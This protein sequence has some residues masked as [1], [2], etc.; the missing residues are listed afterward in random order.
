MRATLN[1]PS[2]DNPHSRPSLLDTVT[3]VS[4]RSRR[5]L[6]VV[7]ALTVMAA[8]VIAARWPVTTSVGVNYKVTVKRL[9]LFEKAIAFVDR[10]LEMRRLTREIAETGGAP[11]QRLLRMYEWVT[12]NIHPVPPG[13]PVVDD[14]VFDIF[15]R[16][17]GAND[18]RAEALAAL[19]SYDGMPATTIALGKNPKR[20]LVQ[21]TV[22]RI[23]DRLVAFDVNNRIVFRKA[24]GE[25][26][27]LNDLVADPSIIRTL[28]HGVVVD[29]APY[30]EHFQ[31]L[32]EVSPSFVR[33]EKQR[34]WP[35]LKDELSDR[36]TMR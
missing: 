1:G 6:G 26:A 19:A 30:A 33:M 18:Q 20:R 15:V 16:R 22:V 4:L 3:V 36:L 31:Q 23:A 29:G 7:G 24:S 13:L 12:D 11:E 32:S 35:R 9:T 5:L 34:F 25:L 17:Y 27:T 14:H 2:L 8:L 10:D 28:G 21:M